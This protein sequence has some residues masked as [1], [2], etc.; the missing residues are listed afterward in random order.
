MNLEMKSVRLIL[1]GENPLRSAKFVPVFGDRLREETDILVIGGLH[2]G[3]E[4]LGG[5]ISD[6]LKKYPLEV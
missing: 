4:P 5:R 3:V 1:K 2:S 6:C